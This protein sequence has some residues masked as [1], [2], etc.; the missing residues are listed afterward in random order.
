MTTIANKNNISYA[1]IVLKI[2]I[3]RKILQ[4]VKTSPA[5]N[6][7]MR[8]YGTEKLK[9]ARNVVL[10]ATAPINEY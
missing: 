8:S 5:L 10:E 6:V 2:Q 1:H 3:N 9:R 7:N 4:V